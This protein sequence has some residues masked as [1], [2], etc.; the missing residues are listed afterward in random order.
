VNMR[1]PVTL[2]KAAATLDV[3]SGG[4]AV[5]GI[6]AGGYEWEARAY[7]YD[8]PRPGVRVERVAETI[9][10][11]RAMWGGS[12]GPVPGRHWRVEAPIGEP[13]PLRGRLPI[14][15]GG[16]GPRLLRLA[17]R[18]ADAVNLFGGPR[19]VAAR[20]ALVREACTR[21]GRDPDK[22]EITWLGSAV[23]PSADLPALARRDVSTARL[24][25]EGRLGSVEA[26]G[27]RLAQLGAAGV[28]H[29]I[30]SLPALWQAGQVE[31][32]GAGLA[33][34]WA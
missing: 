21:A 24:H 16:Q 2:A 4:R 9:A 31:E 28:E 22:V 27:T 3:L 1:H 8:L 29:A 33:A 26:L 7:G 20:A 13:R 18:E 5:L 10:I 34:W 30:L 32:V 25:L 12:A 11:C 17:A 14:L 6:G 19:R 15:V 23:L